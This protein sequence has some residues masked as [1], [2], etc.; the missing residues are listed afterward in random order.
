M[1]P[2]MLASLRKRFD[3]GHG[4]I[5]MMELDML[6]KYAQESMEYISRIESWKRN[7]P[8]V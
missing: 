1:T 5:T 6:I 7:A 4:P 2:E 3:T 8:N